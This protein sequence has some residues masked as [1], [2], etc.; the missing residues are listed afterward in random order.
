MKI[1]HKFEEFTC[2]S[3]ILRLLLYYPWKFVLIFCV[4]DDRHVVDVDASS[5]VGFDDV[6]QM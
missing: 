6:F 4:F 3:F 2:A 5:V 1:R